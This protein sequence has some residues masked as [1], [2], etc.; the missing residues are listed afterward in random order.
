MFELGKILV[1]ASVLGSNKSDSPH[2]SMSLAI[3]LEVT[4][5]SNCILTLYVEVGSASAAGGS[6]IKYYTLQ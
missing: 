4:G 1:I 2:S 5:I 3:T 6:G